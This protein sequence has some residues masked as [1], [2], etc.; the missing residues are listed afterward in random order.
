MLNIFSDPA[1]QAYQ[2]TRVNHWDAVARTRTTQR[3]MGKWYHQRL[4][5]IYGFHVN[6]N[7]RILELGCAEG[8]LLAKLRPARGVG[9]DFSEEM[10][11]RARSHHPNLDFICADVHDLSA[12]NE[13]FDVI[14]LSDLVNDLWDVQAVD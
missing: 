5:E 14:I 3:G 8:H 1:A 2:Q 9:V 6:P 11:N 12:L 7:L 10:L 4:A 13:T